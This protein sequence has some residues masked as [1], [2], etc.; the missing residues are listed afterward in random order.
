MQ[1]QEQQLRLQSLEVQSRH[2]VLQQ[3]V[4]SFVSP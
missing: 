1:D 3:E 2:A 4:G